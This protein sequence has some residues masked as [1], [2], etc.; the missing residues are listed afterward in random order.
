MKNEPGDQPKVPIIRASELAQFS[1]CQRAWWL[2]VAQGYPP[3]NQGTL[4]HGV[5]AHNRHFQHVQTAQR[6]H[7][8]SVFLLGG[9]GLLLLA[10]LLWQ[11]LISYF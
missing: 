3:K 1:F 7:K 2:A 6:W 9:G 8:A 10:V 11:L 4:S 5:S